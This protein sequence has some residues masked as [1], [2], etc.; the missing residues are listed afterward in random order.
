MQDSPFRP[1]SR[2]YSGG[3]ISGQADAPAFAFTAPVNQTIPV[4]IAAP[5][6]GRIY[7][8]TVTGNMRD[9]DYCALRLEDR[10]VDTLA[11]ETARLTGAGLLVAK[12]PRA[13]LDLNRDPDDVD[14]SMISGERPA[15]VLHSQTNRRARSGLGLV[16]R[17]L[18]NFGEIWKGQLDRTELD[19]RIE[20]I[21]RP[22]HA[23]LQKE[24]SHIRDEWGVALLV[25]FHSM[26][27][28]KKRFGEDHAAHFVL[29]DRL[30]ASCDPG[31][32]A[33]ALRYLDGQGQF[34]A[35]N[36]PYSGG[37][38]LD[39]HAAP[40]R[41]IHALQLEICRSRYLD[42]SMEQPSVDLAAMV[43]LM[44]GFIRELAGATVRLATRRDFPQAAE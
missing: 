34:L 19:A 5:H 41:G 6:G 26:P 37:Y 15:K 14:W 4:L 1:D 43:R 40:M 21:H 35:H 12:A 30:G 3:F 16:P 7:P 42:I 20:G 27:P 38:V 8:D 23:A 33:Q 39:R 25:D 11:S 18:P 22:Y 10:Y 36:R 44:A 2:S 32:M 24:L 29:G 31:I 17:R 13:M 9:P 28:L